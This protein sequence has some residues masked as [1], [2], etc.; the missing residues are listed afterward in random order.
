MR[1]PAR[2]RQDAALACALALVT[3]CSGGDDSRIRVDTVSRATV[4]EIVEAPATVAARASASVSSPAEGTVAGLRV[5]DGQDVRAGQVLLRVESPQAR[6]QLRQA[7]T[8]DRRAA[9]GAAG[10]AV[11]VS[12]PAARA[13]DATAQRAFDRAR[14]AVRRI[15]DRATRVQARSALRVSRSQYAAASAQ[16]AA[17]VRALSVGL[18][19]LSAAVGALSSAQRVQTRAAVDVARR[20]VAALTV[21]APIDGTVSLS[22]PPEDGVG[23]TGSGGLLDQLPPE[24]ASRAGDVL[25][26]SA[27]GPAVEAELTQGRPVSTG[28]GLLTV[29]DTSALSLQ[30]QVDETDVL[31]VRPGIPASAELDAVPDATYAADVSAIDPAPTTS[32]RGGVTYVVRLSLGAGSLPGGR[33]APVPR[34]G[35]SA[36]VDLQ[37]RTAARAVAAPAAA[38]FR[39]GRR[40][41]VWAVKNGLARERVVTLGAQGRAQI[42]V[43]EGLAVGERIVVRGADR[44]TDGQR[45][46]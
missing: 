31:L 42:Q 26:G 21:R 17:A 8:A 24:L 9:A 35:M 44:V 13:A 16:A 7:R 11:P 12:L 38:V 22:P 40:D 29:T 25:G 27:S 30:A 20:A 28:Q 3:S 36:V 4:V 18:G 23:T 15:P 6:R 34:P 14:R 19:S 1:T 2:W 46:P 43:L 10:A 32:T 5:R 37:V 39:D 33:T 45:V 41:V